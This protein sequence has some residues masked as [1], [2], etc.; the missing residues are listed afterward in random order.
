MFIT[1]PYS[2]HT[3]FKGSSYQQALKKPRND[4]DPL[5][6]VCWRRRLRKTGRTAAL[7]DW[8]WTNIWLTY[9]VQLFF[10]QRYTAFYPK[11]GVSHKIIT[12]ICFCPPTPFFFFF[13]FN[14]AW[15]LRRTVEKCILMGKVKWKIFFTIY[16]IRSHE[17]RHG[18][19]INIAF[20]E[21][22]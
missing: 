11:T 4:G 17:S 22:E 2:Q 5:N 16:S 18:I 8:R 20:V 12:A 21:N 14:V 19:Q 3:W 7:E 13:L 10:L 15:V 6:H 1:S 9:Y